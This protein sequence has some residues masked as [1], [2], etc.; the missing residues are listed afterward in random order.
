[1]PIDEEKSNSSH[2]DRRHQK[3]KRMLIGGVNLDQNKHNDPQ[4]IKHSSLVN[5]DD[6]TKD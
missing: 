5:I 1:M 2:T 6:S 3:T 4:H